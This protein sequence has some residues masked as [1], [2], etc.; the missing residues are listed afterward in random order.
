VALLDKLIVLEE[1]LA[2]FIGT[3]RFISVVR[4]TVGP[5]L[6]SDE[7]G[8]YPDAYCFKA[9]FNL[10]SSSTSRH[11]KWSLFFRFSDSDFVYIS[12]FL[13]ACFMP[14]PSFPP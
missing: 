12:L 8:L 13:Y 9:L 7:F 2:F 1:F 11:P 5:C 4:G 10:T 3:Q 14:H 6:D